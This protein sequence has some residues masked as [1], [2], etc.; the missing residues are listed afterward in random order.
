MTVERIWHEVD[1]HVTNPVKRAVMEMQ[2]QGR[3]QLADPVSKFCTSYVLV[4]VCDVGFQRFID[5]WNNHSISGSTNIRKCP[6]C[7][8]MYS[9]IYFQEVASVAEYLMNGR[10]EIIESPPLLSMR[11][12]R[13]RKPLLCTNAMV[14][15]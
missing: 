12:Q 9:C 3:L 7:M 8:L 13:E 10:H 14:G 2:S 6:V 4:N 15:M 5:V 11:C 1:D